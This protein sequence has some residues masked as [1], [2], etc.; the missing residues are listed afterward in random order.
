MVHGRAPQRG[1]SSPPSSAGDP[2]SARGGGLQPR[3]ATQRAASRLL[4]GDFF[5][6]G[7]RPVEVQVDVSRR[8]HP[9]F[10]IVGLA[11][12]SIRES[13]ERIRAAIRNSQFRFPHKDYV[14]VNLAPAAEQKDGAG[15]DL[16]IA[17]GILLATRQVRCAGGTNG[18]SRL[19]FLGE[20]GLAGEVRPVAGGLLVADALRTRGVETFVTATGNAAEA[21]LVRGLEVLPVDDLSTAA[22]LLHDPAAVV[23][24]GDREGNEPLVPPRD[25]PAVSGL[26]FSEVKGQETTKRGLLVSATGEH[27][28]MLVGPP[29]VG[30]TMLVKRLSGI[31]PAMSYEEAI[32]VTRILSVDCK[33]GGGTLAVERPFRAPHHTIS[34]AGL[35]GG[36]TIPRPGEITRAHRG[37]LFLDELAEFL[38]R[39]LEALREPLE[40]GRIT[41][42]RGSGTVTY[43]T[44]VL[45]VAA[46]N[47][48]PCGF[49]GHPTRRCECSPGAI[50]AYRGRLSGPLLDRLD[51]FLDVEPVP[52]SEILRQHRGDGPASAALRQKVSAGRRRQHGR[53]GS[54]LTNARVPLSRLLAEGL[55]SPPALEL[56]RSHAESLGL[57]ARG[58]ARTL[59]VA[60]TIADVDACEQVADAHILEAL[61]YRESTLRGGGV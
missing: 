49:W 51:L 22:A 55:F 31:L 16:A 53:W 17:L 44:V 29:G 58:F 3:P 23:L 46:M 42:S 24:Q 21:A 12:K 30:K 50:R 14:I 52:P 45:L 2:S 34:Y 56:L 59:R 54:A 39:P 10:H 35:V 27:N 26:D 32:E 61:H 6:L 36:G 41:I 20:L 11:S 8:G 4:S 37:V 1:S 40:E 5:G 18:A 43:P 28:A 9:G 33:G 7:G 48:C 47:P 19:G 15:F 38:R 60:R 57:S 13:R 25:A